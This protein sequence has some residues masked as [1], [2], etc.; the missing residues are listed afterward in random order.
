MSRH[1]SFPTAIRQADRGYEAA[2]CAMA[3]HMAGG[4]GFAAK[5]NGPAWLSSEP[6]VV[7]L[8]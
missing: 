4:M 3:V 6:W 7:S 5:A 1:S 8:M 2:R